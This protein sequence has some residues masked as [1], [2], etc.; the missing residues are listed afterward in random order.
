MRT[1]EYEQGNAP[2]IVFFSA[3]NAQIVRVSGT[4][5]CAKLHSELKYL[6]RNPR[7]N[8]KLRQY[9]NME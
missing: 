8:E 2:T 4:R 9:D 1:Q 7:M 5:N 6:G 3:P